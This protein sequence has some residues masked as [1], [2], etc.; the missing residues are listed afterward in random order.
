M[1]LTKDSRLSARVWGRVLNAPLYDG[2]CSP[3]AREYLAAG[4][5]DAAVA[6]WRRLADLGS[7][8]ARCVLAYVYFR[9]TPSVP[10]DFVEAKRIALSAVAGERGYAN[11]LL[12]CFALKEKQIGAAIKCFVESHKAGFVPAE[13]AMAALQ[14]AG[15]SEERKQT[16][17]TM[18]RRAS[19]AGHLPA[20]LRLMG[21]YLSGQL[22]FSKRLLGIS[23]FPL[24]ALQFMLALRYQIFS[25]RCFQGTAMQKDSLFNVDSIL[26]MQKKGAY[27]SDRV[28]L[29]GLRW[30][31]AIGATTAAI[32]LFDRSEII[33]GKSAISF[34]GSAVGWVLLA[35]WPY[36]FSY[37]VAS[38][39]NVRSF[40]STVVQATLLCLITALA[41]NS[42]MGH[43]IDVTLN[44]WI[45]GAITVAQAFLL[46]SGCG[47][48]ERAAQEFGATSNATP[49][50]RSRIL[51][52]HIVLGL[53]ARWIVPVTG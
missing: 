32:V 9:G 10:A 35:V 39:L 7:G 31:H 36:G 8:R 45:I 12:G 41:C 34:D 19:A 3:G 18:L 40:V 47:L 33:A 46:Q 5:V 6:E 15:A 21:M 26:R 50:Y 44:V 30:I 43:L 20:R 11:Y 24:I 13:T 42:Y 22:G 28:R 4:N 17:V 23:L 16:V 52:A 14:L 53:M 37:L 49:P 51:W 1:L 27:S 25:I 29:M 48:G 38:K 2:N